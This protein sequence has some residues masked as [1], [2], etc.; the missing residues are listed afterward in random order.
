MLAEKNFGNSVDEGVRDRGGMC[1]K[2]FLQVG[3]ETEEV[4]TKHS[5]MSENG[6]GFGL[7]YHIDVPLSNISWVTKSAKETINQI[8]QKSFDHK[9]ITLVDDDINRVILKEKKGA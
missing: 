9:R 4:H 5:L 3:I 8:K 7:L 2:A 6:A 1:L